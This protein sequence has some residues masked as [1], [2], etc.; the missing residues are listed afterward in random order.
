MVFPLAIKVSKLMYEAGFE[1]SL[2]VLADDN[3]TNPQRTQNAG[4]ISS[5][6]MLKEDQW[7]VFANGAEIIAEA[8]KTKYGIKT[9]FHHHCARIYRNA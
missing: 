8:V 2:I 7:N 4:R 6:M 9:V 1:N 3:G 5:D